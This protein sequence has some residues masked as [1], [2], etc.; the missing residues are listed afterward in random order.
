MK[1]INIGENIILCYLLPISLWI[2]VFVGRQFH[3]REWR[4]HCTSERVFV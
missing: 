3:S 2:Y 4:V 1:R